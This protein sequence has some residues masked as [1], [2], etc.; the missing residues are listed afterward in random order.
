MSGSD[1]STSPG[2]LCPFWCGQH[3]GQVTG[4]DDWIHISRPNNSTD[5]DTGRL[6][7]S[8]DPDTG[9]ADGPYVL[10]DGQQYTLEEAEGL[11]RAL[12]ALAATARG[13]QSQHLESA[14]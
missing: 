9:V 12:M 4:E 11:A 13:G 8:V 14:G 3:H 7:M 10:V 5:G 1:T 6:C 2:E